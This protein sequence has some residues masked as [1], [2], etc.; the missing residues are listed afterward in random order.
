[1]NNKKHICFLMSG[2][3]NIDNTSCTGVTM[4]CQGLEMY[5][6]FINVQNCLNKFSSYC[7]RSLFRSPFHNIPA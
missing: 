1:M 3:T 6:K 2:L 5:N 7:L 4:E